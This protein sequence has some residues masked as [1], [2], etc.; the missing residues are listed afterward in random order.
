MLVLGRKHRQFF[1][2]MFV[3][4]FYAGRQSEYRICERISLYSSITICLWYDSHLFIFISVL[5]QEGWWCLPFKC[6]PMIS[7]EME[8]WSHTGRHTAPIVPREPHAPLTTW[9][10]SWW[11]N[12]NKFKGR[13]TIPKSNLQLFLPLTSI[14][15]FHSACRADLPRR[16]HWKKNAATQKIINITSNSSEFQWRVPNWEVDFQKGR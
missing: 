12:I 4:L 8:G 6:A 2:N 16:A 11:I 5:L 7:T 14:S 15:P 9:I 1:L 3:S 13:R 10:W